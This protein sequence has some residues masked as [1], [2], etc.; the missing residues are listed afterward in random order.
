MCEWLLQKSVWNWDKTALQVLLKILFVCLFV[1]QF[2]PEFVW[3][4]IK[5]K[6]DG[7]TIYD[8]SSLPCQPC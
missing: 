7:E 5:K 8:S 6:K 2:P 4:R 1:K 3:F